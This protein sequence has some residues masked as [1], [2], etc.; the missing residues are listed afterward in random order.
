[1]ILHL[2]LIIF[3][4]LLFYWA[5]LNY[6]Y[7]S[8]DIP[9]SAVPNEE[10]KKDLVDLDE[11]LKIFV[12]KYPNEKN[13]FIPHLTDLHNKWISSPPKNFWKGVWLQLRGQR[14]FNARHAHIITLT[15]HIINTLLIYLAF[16]CNNVSLIASLLFAINP[17]N[18]QGG[19]IWISGK[20]YS[21]ATTLVL[22][23][24]VLPY[25]SPVF[26]YLTSFCSAS[27]MFS[28]LSFVF[29]K[30]W[31]LASMPFLAFP[32]LRNVIKKKW[33]LNNT[34]N[35][36]MVAIV[37]RKIIPFMKSYGYYFRLCVIPYKLGLYHSFLWGLGVSQK[38]NKKA[39]KLDKNFWTGTILFLG[40][41]YLIYLNHSNLFGFGLLWFMINIIMWCNIC[42]VQQQIADRYCYL[43]CIGIM[44][45]LSYLAYHSPSPFNY[46]LLTT[47]FTYYGTRLWNYRFAYM[48][49]YWQI[50]YNV[51]E[52]PNAHYAWISRGIKKFF[53]ND[54]D[55]AL[56][57][58]C[59]SRNFV[60]HDFKTNFNM[61]TMLF[62]LG[63]LPQC[64]I[65]LKF[66][67]E[68]HYEGV[69]ELQR[70]EFTDHLR[71]LIEKRKR[72]ENIPLQDVRII[73]IL[74]LLFL[75]GRLLY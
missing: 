66:A 2:L 70:K 58:F 49:D 72:N 32:I 61:A 53:F 37:P 14:Y 9:C 60:D 30:Y 45:S 36:E 38:Y 23:M 1:M 25:A 3:V 19:A 65:Y 29:T 57:D 6:W 12:N 34:S 33:C 50:E 20:P 42:T 16:G 41:A 71:Q 46:I 8:D 21:T 35:R 40:S 56:R 5:T 69:E 22:L 7:V 17:I 59:E 48:N 31:F 24:Y 4:N 74:P 27:A 63:D 67:E 13:Q 18:A 64:E 28:P 11:L 26:F 10:K 68:N 54:F 43:P 47:I 75:I 39:Y 51:M 73:K 62:C 52:Q 15:V 55:G 44:L